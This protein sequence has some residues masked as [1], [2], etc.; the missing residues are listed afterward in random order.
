MILLLIEDSVILRLC[1][2][3]TL[4]PLFLKLGRLGTQVISRCC[5]ATSQRPHSGRD[6]VCNLIMTS[7]VQITQFTNKPS[8]SATSDY[9]F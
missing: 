6:I 9:I 3:F 2:Y 5:W 4:T 7:P 8:L 1:L